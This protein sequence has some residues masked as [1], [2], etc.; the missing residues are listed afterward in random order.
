M[1]R[2]APWL[3]LVNLDTGT[4]PAHLITMNKLKAL[5]YL[6]SI[7]S[8]VKSITE[9]VEKDGATVLDYEVEELRRADDALDS[10]RDGM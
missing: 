2:G 10:L 1:P 4:T 3:H 5:E 6:Q 7:L 9:A 8:S